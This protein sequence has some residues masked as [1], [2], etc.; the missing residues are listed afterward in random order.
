MAYLLPVR[1]RVLDNARLQEGDTL[2]DVG[3]GD[4]LIAFGALDRLARGQVIFCDISADLIAH[5]RAL[6]AELAAEE[7]EMARRCQ[8]L[9]A[10]ADDLHALADGSVDVV[11]TRSVLIYVR[12]KATA[13]HEFYRVLRPGG[14]LSI[15][16]PINRYFLHA[17]PHLFAG[18]DV[19][20]VMDLAER[21]MAI[22][23][24]PRAQR[25]D[26]M[27]NFDQEDLVTFAQ[28]AGFADVRL[29]LQVEEDAATAPMRWETWLQTAPNPTAPSYA[30][31]IYNALLP[32]EVERFISHLRPLV[33]RGE[34]EPIRFAVAYLAAQKPAPDAG[35]P[36]G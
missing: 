1:D 17:E 11:T 22:Y 28:E 16:E 33:E 12:D 23:R 2:L 36:P 9:Q 3:C 14:R 15:F 6:V 34:R 7:P 35:G 21:I 30:E 32:D 25:D 29:D 31:V 13:F 4:G 26:P 24:P 5:V 27:L 10:A 20:P 19:T 18:Y 8:F